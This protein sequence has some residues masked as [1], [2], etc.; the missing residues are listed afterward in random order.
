V[1][2]RTSRT[3]AKLVVLRLLQSNTDSS[4]VARVRSAFARSVNLSLALIR[5]VPLKLAPVR[6]AGTRKASDRLVSW[7]Q[8]IA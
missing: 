7:Q 5:L 8:M 4:R 2:A 3:T 1:A 6:S